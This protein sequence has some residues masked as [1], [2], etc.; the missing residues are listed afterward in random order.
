L[1]ASRDA[2]E[3]A[4]LHQELQQPPPSEAPVDGDELPEPVAEQPKKTLGLIAPH[5]D[6]GGVWRSALHNEEKCWLFKS[7]VKTHKAPE[8]LQVDADGGDE[9]QKSSRQTPKSTKRSKAEKAAEKAEKEKAEKE[10]AEKEAAEQQA[11]ADSEPVEVITYIP[12]SQIS[13]I[14][15]EWQFE[16]S[17]VDALRCANKLAEGREEDADEVNVRTQDTLRRLLNLV[18]PFSFD[19]LSV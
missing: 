14:N 5:G 8:K 1:Q 4:A 11:N 19:Q 7:N 15:D 10:K 18:R 6:E 3:A 2:L 13:Q 16:L 12:A 9:P 17:H